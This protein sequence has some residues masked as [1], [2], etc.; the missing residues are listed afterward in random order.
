MC[1]AQSAKREAQY[2]VLLAVCSIESLLPV[3]VACLPV[4][5]LPVGIGI[6]GMANGPSLW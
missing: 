5:S 4:A 1:R 3:A 6:V 2:A